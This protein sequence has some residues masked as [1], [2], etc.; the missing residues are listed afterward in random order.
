MAAVCR[1]SDKRLPVPARARAPSASSGR[2]TPSGIA[3]RRPVRGAGKR[4]PS[5]LARAGAAQLKRW[6]EA[7][8]RSRRRRTP[9]RAEDAR[10]RRRGRLVF[11]RTGDG[12]RAVAGC[13]YEAAIANE[14][15]GMLEGRAPPRARRAGAL[16][17]KLRR[18]RARD[19]APLSAAMSITPARRAASSPARS[20]RSRTSG[21][22]QSGLIAYLWWCSEQLAHRQHV[23]GSVCA[24]GRRC[25][26]SGSRTCGRPS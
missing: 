11:W 6:P 25:R 22:R 17:I 7:A 8:A 26:S 4:R 10:A 12:G 3:R 20:G 9:A 2:W 16:I 18:A 19:I 13:H 24:S 23:Q 21:P 15:A 1:M 14:G 5:S